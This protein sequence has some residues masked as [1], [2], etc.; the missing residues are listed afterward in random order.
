MATCGGTGACGP[1]GIGAPG[2]RPPL[3]APRAAPEG[4][5]AGAGWALATIAKLTLIIIAVTKTRID[6]FMERSFPD[7]ALDWRKAR[8][9]GSQPPSR[10]YRRYGIVW[11]IRPHV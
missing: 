10:V 8:A 7:C 3:P 5:V 11:M 6:R 9:D 1:I 2:P 4:A